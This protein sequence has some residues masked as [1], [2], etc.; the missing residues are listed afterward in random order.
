[1]VA[2][3]TTAKTSSLCS[4]SVVTRDVE[5]V[6]KEQGRLLVEEEDE[7]GEMMIMWFA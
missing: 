5:K 7:D 2:S 4:Y 1:M 3:L 6:K